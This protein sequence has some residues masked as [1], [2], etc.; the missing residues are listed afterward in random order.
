MFKKKVKETVQESTPQ[1]KPVLVD[2]LLKE[3]PNLFDRHPGDSVNRGA[4]EKLVEKIEE[5][6]G[7]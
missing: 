5:L 3:I 7:N 4:V 2:L 1:I 6:Y